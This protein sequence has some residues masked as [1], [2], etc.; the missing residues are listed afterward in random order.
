MSL[1]A[2]I[3]RSVVEL[4]NCTFASCLKFIPRGWMRPGLGKW[5]SD[6]WGC[7]YKHTKKSAVP[8]GTW[9]E[10]QPALLWSFHQHPLGLTALCYV[11]STM[12]EPVSKTILGWSS[13]RQ[14]SD[15]SDPSWLNKD[16]SEVYKVEKSPLDVFLWK[17]FIS[18]RCWGV[19]LP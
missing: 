3:L 13:G 8:P 11:P 14:T 10:T 9:D 12:P 16:F 2:G 4:S 1:R 18:M 6:T 5:S 15:H 17:I 7:L 19:V